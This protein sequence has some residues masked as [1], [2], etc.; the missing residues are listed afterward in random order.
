[1]E[2]FYLFIGFLLWEVCGLFLKDPAGSLE[3][4]KSIQTNA[5]PN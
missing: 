5:T 2:L 3:D 1:M 4:D